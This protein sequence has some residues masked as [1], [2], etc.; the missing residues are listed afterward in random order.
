MYLV[1]HFHCLRSNWVLQIK[2]ASY[3]LKCSLA[4]FIYILYS[5][6][7]Y[8]LRFRFFDVMGLNP[9][10]LCRVTLQTFSHML[11]EK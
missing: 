4:I 3:G 6:L 2:A 10:L 7:L 5:A 9:G 11:C 1:I 8:L